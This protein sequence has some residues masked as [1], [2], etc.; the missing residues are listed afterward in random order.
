MFLCTYVGRL[1]RSV[2][3]VG[4][5]RRPID[6]TGLVEVVMVRLRDCVIL[7]PKVG[8]LSAVL[9]SAPSIKRGLM[10]RVHTAPRK[11]SKKNMVVW[12]VCVCVHVGLRDTGRSV[13]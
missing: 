1:V 6:R 2:G 10:D 8:I 7:W 3:L 5:W 4:G 13:F 9:F 12:C 11:P